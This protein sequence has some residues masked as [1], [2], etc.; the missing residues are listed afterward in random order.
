[1]RSLYSGLLRA[2]QTALEPNVK[3][4]YDLIDRLSPTPPPRDET[5]TRR[6]FVE[7]VAPE[8]LRASLAENAR[9]RRYYRNELNA[10]LSARIN[11]KLAL[12]LCVAACFFAFN[13]CFD[14][15]YLSHLRPSGIAGAKGA[16]EIDAIYDYEL[17]SARTEKEREN[18]QKRREIRLRNYYDEVDFSKIGVLTELSP[19]YHALAL[20]T[21]A[22]QLAGGAYAGYALYRA[23]KTP[24]FNIK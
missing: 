2:A 6:H 7:N 17:L 21:L 10:Y 9:P 23:F 5:Q 14:R 3:P 19:L 24:L 13:F 4:I 20:A 22:A 1:M 11:R 18:I 12:A 15:L 16:L 8:A